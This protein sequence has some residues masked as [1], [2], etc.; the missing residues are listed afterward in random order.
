[1]RAR[2]RYGRLKCCDTHPKRTGK[3][4]TQC[5]VC[6]AMWLGKRIECSIYE[7]DLEDLITFAN[8]FTKR[9]DPLKVVRIEDE[10]SVD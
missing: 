4:T 2:F 5:V 10:N 6:W 7:S 8:K 9:I 1:M 3:P